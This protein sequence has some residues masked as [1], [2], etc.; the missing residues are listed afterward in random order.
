MLTTDQSDAGRTSVSP[1][2]CAVSPS[3]LSTASSYTVS[4]GCG[5]FVPAGCPPGL[6]P[7]SGSPISASSATTRLGTGGAG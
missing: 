2:A 7:S 6:P 1:P 3:A 4:G 5:R